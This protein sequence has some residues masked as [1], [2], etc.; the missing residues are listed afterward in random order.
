MESK[1]SYRIGPGLRT[2]LRQMV[3]AFDGRS[4]GGGAS[5][6]PTVS[7]EMF[8][9]VGGGPFIRLCKTTSAWDKGT[10]A[11]L[12][13]YENGEPPSETSSGTLTGCV[14]KT[15]NVPSGKFVLVGKA[16][17]GRWYLVNAE[18]G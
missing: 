4:I 10:I 14:N 3:D 9:R 12:D 16:A 15:Q 17:N 1:E 5:G 6:I 2:K 13:L 11:T 8:R 7:Q 18:C